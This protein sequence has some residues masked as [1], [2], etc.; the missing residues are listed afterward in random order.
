M[1]GYKGNVLGGR[2]PFIMIHTEAHKAGMDSID[3]FENYN[4]GAKKTIPSSVHGHIP[5]CVVNIFTSKDTKTKRNKSHFC[6]IPC[7]TDDTAI[8]QQVTGE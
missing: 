6:H 4:M 2:G 5:G 7:R 1:Q 3:C 8:G